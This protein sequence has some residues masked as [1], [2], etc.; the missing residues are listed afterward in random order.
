MLHIKFIIQKLPV[1]LYF[2]A[3]TL[4]LGQSEPLTKI[5]YYER[6]LAKPQPRKNAGKTLSFQDRKR[7]VLDKGNLVLR[8]SNAA[9]YG[10]DPWGL[11]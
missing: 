6:Y 1:L 4:V 5:E 8:M 7:S 11:P 2:V 10:Y 9:I 3:F